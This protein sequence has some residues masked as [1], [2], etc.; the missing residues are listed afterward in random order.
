M[1]KHGQ[2]SELGSSAQTYLVFCSQNGCDAVGGAAGRW[3]RPEVRPPPPDTICGLISLV[4]CTEPAVMVI[5]T[6]RVDTL[7]ASAKTAAI[8]ARSAAPKSKNGPRQREASRHFEG[9]GAGRDER[10][11]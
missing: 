5:V 9:L 11:G 2:F 8:E 3:G 10:E 6:A 7:A 4:T 1:Q